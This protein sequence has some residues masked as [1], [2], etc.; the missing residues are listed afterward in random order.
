M[1][2][3]FRGIGSRIFISFS[4]LFLFVSL[5]VG[6]GAWQYLERKTYES[7]GNEL[8]VLSASLVN[9]LQKDIRKIRSQMQ[10]LS[11]FDG[12]IDRWMRSWKP[13]GEKR[14]L[15]QAL[16]EKKLPQ[17]G[18]FEEFY[19]FDLDGNSI[20]QTD[21]EWPTKSVR[22]EEFFRLGTGRMRFAE[23]FEDPKYY[24]LVLLIT[25]P[26]GDPEHPSGVLAGKVKLSH[27]NDFLD[28]KL[29]IRGDAE[30][31]LLD[32]K[33]RFLTS[34]QS[35]PMA[36]Q[37]LLQSH[38]SN[39]PLIDHLGDEFWVGK[40]KNFRGV[41]VLG[42]VHRTLGYDGFLVI[43]REDASIAENL[44]ALKKSI[45]TG[46]ALLVLGLLL[47]TVLI[48]KSMTRPIERLAESARGIG[49]GNLESPVAALPGQDEI[50]LLGRTLESMRVKV[51]Q[52]QRQLRDRLEMS[53]QKRIQSERLA[54]I[55][56]LA[57]SLAHEIRNPL[58][59]MNLLLSQLELK[60]QAQPT[61]NSAQNRTEIHGIRSE[62]FRLDRLVGRILDYAKPLQLR[63]SRVDLDLLLREVTEFYKN[64]L[65]SSGLEIEYV[66]RGSVFC[67]CDRDQ[68]KQ[69]MINVLQNSFESMEQIM[70]GRIDI[71]L[72][73]IDD[74]AMITIQDQGR[75]VLPADQDRLFDLFF[76]TKDHGTG[77]GLTTVK[78]IVDAHEGQ[79]RLESTPGSGTRV[80]LTI[81][82]HR[83]Q[84]LQSIVT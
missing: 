12:N 64:I 34:T 60:L 80:E 40:Y 45:V 69:A 47:M 19:V 82:L 6:I 27:L 13:T 1:N 21:K 70:R 25:A 84:N 75:G 49:E 72:E 28:Q 76:S 36:T 55:G 31:F 30:A 39:A 10:S 43:E 35:A 37:S 32:D 59:G 62:I 48:T 50:A 56:V 8:G 16:L 17:T 58:N 53:E 29:G 79:I 4:T 51:N 24:A 42:T 67:F 7:A 9:R 22:E 68:L 73:T 65:K 71:R 11:S 23:I 38:L 54:A 57:S 78:K 2:R 63:A 33:L 14:K 3:I 20:G 26:I 74:K 15:I 83:D 81:P 41:E 44:T 5:F 77:L 52:F 61:G 18:L 66:R 46:F